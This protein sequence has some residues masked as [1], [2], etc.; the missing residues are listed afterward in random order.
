MYAAPEVLRGEGAY[1]EKVD[2]YSFGMLLIDVAVVTGGLDK[3]TEWRW[4][5]DHGNP[6][7]II[8]VLN[9]IIDGEWHPI[10]N[11]KGKCL[12]SAPLAIQE[13]ASEC[14][15]YDSSARPSFQEILKLLTGSIADDIL[16]SSDSLTFSRKP[17]HADE[18]SGSNALN[19]RNST[20]A[21]STL[22]DESGVKIQRLHGSAFAVSSDV[23]SM[24]SSI[25]GS[26]D[27]L[28]AEARSEAFPNI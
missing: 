5:C 7:R 16:N 15:A 23:Q 3:F 4:L 8:R 22:K 13:L 10:A 1:N 18:E 21:Q 24:L 26:S 12:D 20:S 17:P 27:L 2:V 19:P 9:A 25:R 11:N 14:C 6:R 28:K